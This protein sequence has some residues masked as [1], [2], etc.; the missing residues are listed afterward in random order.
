MMMKR[1]FE[2][3]KIHPAQKS[4]A[5]LKKR[6]RGITGTDFDTIAFGTKRQIEQLVLKKIGKPLK[7]FTGN[8]ATRHGEKY[9]SEAIEKFKLIFPHVTVR[10]DV[11]MITHAEFPE[12]RFFSP[13]GVS[14]QGDLLEV[15]CPFSRKINGSIPRNYISQVQY[16]MD[17]MHSHGEHIGNQCYFIQYKPGN[18]GDPFDRQILSVKIIPRDPNYVD[19]KLAQIANFKKTKEEYRKFHD[20][21][22]EN[23]F[24]LPEEEGYLGDDSNIDNSEDEGNGINREDVV[25][26]I[27][28]I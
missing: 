23:K 22:D 20:H 25:D 24:F 1:I 27:K 9:E 5:W 8:E 10:D 15:K 28:S 17:I 16:G 13:D 18:F 4:P 6:L 2:E 11:S 14:V 7:P 21:H 12:E 19:G 26:E 3:S